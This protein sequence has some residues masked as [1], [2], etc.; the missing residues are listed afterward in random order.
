MAKAAAATK[1]EPKTEVSFP[2]ARLINASLFEKDVYINPRGKEGTPAYKIEVAFDP[3]DVEGEKTIEDVIINAACD[4]WGDDAENLYL[5]GKIRFFLDGDKLAKGREERG[6]AGDAYKGTLVLRSN[7]IYNKDGVDGPGGIQVYAPD[8]S[9]I[10]VANQG[11]IYPGCYVIIAGTF[12][13]YIDDDGDKCMKLYLS[14]VQKTRDG[15]RLVAQ[16]D[17]STLFKPVGRT[18]AAAEGGGRRSRKG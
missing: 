10:T 9:E 17:R 1:S 7:T 16:R 13:C 4:E 14:A 8:V 5:D 6:K 18:A 11:E 2:E 3:K 15:E 12:H